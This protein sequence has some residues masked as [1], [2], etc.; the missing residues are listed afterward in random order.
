MSEDREQRGEHRRVVFGD[1][2]AAAGN[3][4]ER[5]TSNNGTRKRE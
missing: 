4:D 2:E 1:G 3:K 5:K